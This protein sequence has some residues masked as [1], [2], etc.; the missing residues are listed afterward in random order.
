M[1]AR[2]TKQLPPARRLRGIVLSAAATL[3]VTLAA[4]ETAPA[5]QAASQRLQATAAT[6]AWAWRGAAAEESAVFHGVVSY[7]TAGGG[8]G[9]M[10]YPAPGPAG[11][12]VAILTHAAINSGARSAEAKRIEEAADKVLVPLKDQVD[13]LRLRDLQQDALARWEIGTEVK[14]LGRD[15][16]ADNAWIVETQPVFLMTQDRRA[17][18]VEAVVRL[19]DGAAK[20][21]AI[22]RAVRVVSPPVKGDVDGYWLDPVNGRLA[23]TS[24]ALLAEAIRVAVL[25]AQVSG[26]SSQRTIRY[27]E[28]GADKFERATLLSERCERVALRTLRG[29]VMSVPARPKLTPAVSVDGAA[30]PAACGAA[31]PDVNGPVAVVNAPA[32]AAQTAAQTVAVDGASAGQPAAA[33]VAGDSVVKTPQ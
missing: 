33:A 17:L 29:G 9:A 1:R 11:F 18:V 28:G 20:V 4:A 13:R 31:W 19:F 7:D 6:R 10:L 5:E 12:L 26:D 27:V 22:E 32:T 23:Q 2:K 24:A 3:A 15:E 8:A 14:L 16:N 21:P 25:D 30:G